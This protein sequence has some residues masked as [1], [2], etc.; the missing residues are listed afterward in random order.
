MNDVKKQIEAYL[1]K[2][3]KA[4]QAQYELTKR[5]DLIERG[6]YEIKFSAEYFEGCEYDKKSKQYFIK[7]PLEVSDEDYERIKQYP[8][9]DKKSNLEY[10]LKII[11]V[12]I[13]ISG[14]VYGIVTSTSDAFIL[15]LIW[16]SSIAL[17]FLYFALAQILSEKK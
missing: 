6:L 13:I 1:S 16:V 2:Q 10:I 5:E 12:L 3:E 15:I 17:G 9:R 8:V 7:E 11:G 4:K 14:F